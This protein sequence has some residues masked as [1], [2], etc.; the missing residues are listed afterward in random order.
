M[1][2][3]IRRPLRVLSGEDVAVALRTVD[4]SAGV[5]RLVL[6]LS[7][8]EAVTVAARVMDVSAGVRLSCP[9]LRREGTLAIA[10]LAV[11][12]DAGYYLGVAIL[13]V[14]VGA[15]LALGGRDVPALVRVFGVVGAQA[16]AVRLC[17]QRHGREHGQTQRQGCNDAQYSTFHSPISS[18][19]PG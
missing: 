19:S 5:R 3:G 4:V 2:T 1:G 12:M 10:A 15:G 18:L 8:E 11:D 17:R 7:G 9:A 14:L 13:C 16:G 6:P